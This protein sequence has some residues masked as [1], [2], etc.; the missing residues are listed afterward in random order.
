MNAADVI[1]VKTIG[2]R[3]RTCFTCVRECP[4]K[5]IRIEDGQAMVLHERC[6]GCGNC[7]QVCSQ[8]AKQAVDSLEL[9]EEI[10]AG[11]SQVA[12]AIAPSFA[13]E[14]TNMTRTPWPEC[15]APWVLILFT[16]LG[17]GPT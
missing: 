9:A 3:C 8:G 12:A 14:F 6:I 7:V 13:A 10:L 17:L 2:E 5:A 4:A 15:C 11:N 1:L 16:K